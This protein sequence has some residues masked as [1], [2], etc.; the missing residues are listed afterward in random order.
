MPRASLREHLWPG[1]PPAARAPLPP[2]TGKDGGVAWPERTGAGFAGAQEARARP[3][4]FGRECAVGC[5]TGLR[6]PALAHAPF[7]ILRPRR[8]LTASLSRVG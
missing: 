8:A 6:P 3:R 4:A 1:A 5:W 7:P 2:G